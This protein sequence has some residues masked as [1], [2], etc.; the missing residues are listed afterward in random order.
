M[1]VALAVS[2][3]FVY[4]ITIDHFLISHFFFF[5]TFALCSGQW[6]SLLQVAQDVKEGKRPAHNKCIAEKP[7]LYS[8]INERIKAQEA[9]YDAK[10]VKN[11]E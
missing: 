10:K 1:S 3:M 6:G 11:K 4:V 8:W 9:R 5:S 2:S 7:E